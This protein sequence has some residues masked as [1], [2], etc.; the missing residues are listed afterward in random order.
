MRVFIAIEL[1]PALQARIYQA[2]QRLRHE[3]PGKW[4]EQENLHLTLAFLGEVQPAQLPGITQALA[5][6]AAGTPP[7]NYATGGL[8]GIPTRAP[9]V[10]A[11]AINTLPQFIQLQREC[12][13][14]LS[15]LGLSVSVRPP[16]LTLVRLSRLPL[17]RPQINFSELKS[18][19]TEISLMQSTLTPRGPIYRRLKALK[20]TSGG[21]QPRL[22][23]NVA[24][25]VINPKNEV[26][27]IRS[28]EHSPKDWQFPQGGVEG[29]ESLLAA[30][31]R[32]LKEEVGITQ[33]EVLNIL[34][35]V[36]KYH[37]SKAFLKRK[38]G[39]S[40]G[41]FVGQEQSLAIVCVKD[42]RPRLKPH[43]REAAEVKWVPHYEL[44]KAIS[45][46]RRGLGRIAMVEL[47]RLMATKH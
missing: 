41:G 45:P 11:L 12:K 31:K 30:A 37:W 3:L 24:I 10:V 8:I 1:A 29:D 7:F 46:K 47:E 40:K 5:D 39:H 13:N 33:V 34:E 26:L 38:Q 35:R 14:T 43:P 23:P 36:Y 21:P 4:V 15:A 20:L 18:R 44:N 28:R 27:L 19:A 42:L 17:H 25:C 32:E 9:R 6:V 22:R 16:H 2:T